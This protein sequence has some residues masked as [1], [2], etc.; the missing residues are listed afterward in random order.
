MWLSH[1]LLALLEGSSVT[2]NHGLEGVNLAQGASGHTQRGTFGESKVR[3][4][5]LQG[6][7]RDI[8]LS[9]WFAITS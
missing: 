9:W 8:E 7:E 6:Y 3:R 5:D 2:R 4:L 1:L